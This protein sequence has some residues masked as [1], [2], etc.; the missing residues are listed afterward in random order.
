MSNCVIVTVSIKP[1]T[2]W[3]KEKCTITNSKLFSYVIYKIDLKLDK[4]TQ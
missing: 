1:Y 4:N 2:G 3:A